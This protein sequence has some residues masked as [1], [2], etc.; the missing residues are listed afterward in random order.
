MSREIYERIINVDNRTLDLIDT[1]QVAIYNLYHDYS[2]FHLNSGREHYRLLMYASTQTTNSVIFDVGTY[3]CMSSIALSYSGKNRIRS[4][5]IKREL[6][7]NPIVP[8]ASYFIGDVRHDALLKDSPLVFLDVAHDGTFE[9]LFYDHL[10]SI[11]W[12]GVLLLDD[13][14]LNDPMKEFWK[15]ITEEKKDITDVGHWSGTGIA[16]FE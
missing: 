5:D 10:R 11:G 9:N 6:P 15:S 16:L 8:H 14:H 1:R 4:Y 2:Y 12:K 3:R 7:A 13:I